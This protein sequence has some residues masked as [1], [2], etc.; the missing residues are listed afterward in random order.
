MRFRNSLRLL[1]ENFGNVYKML[2]YKLAVTII[3]AALSAALVVPRLVTILESSQWL[4]FVEYLKSFFKAVTSGDTQYLANFQQE[5]TGE[6]G[7]V[8][9]LLAFLKEMLPSL[10]WAMMGVVFFY[11]LKRVADTLCHYTVGGMLNDRMSAYTETPFS[12]SFVK[13][14]GKAFTYAL[15]YV[16]LMFLYNVAMIS[17]CYFLFFY[18]L[19]LLSSQLLLS[20]FLTIT[21]IVLAESLKMT[22]TGFW[23]ARD[24][25]GRGE[26][27]LGN[28]NQGKDFF[29][30][31]RQ[32]FF[33]VCG[34][35]VSD[36]VCERAG[37]DFHDRKH[38]AFNDSRFV[39]S[40]NLRAVRELLHGNGAPVFP[41]VRS[42]V[43]GPQLRRRGA[44]P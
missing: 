23:A 12:G 21:F 7:A 34:E 26:N 4:E 40:F 3:F 8:Q 18:L 13:N 43:C 22:L 36:F 42:R 24:D 30:A 37:R 41:C 31:V 5:F 10:V 27:R 32:D 6:N 38:A 14:L 2:L 11:L 28:E 44:L 25:D 33:R 17:L 19:R 39:L 9:N 29:S 35:R 16:P 20:L 15:V 1:M